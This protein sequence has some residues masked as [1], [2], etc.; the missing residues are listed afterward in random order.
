MLII[1]KKG[2][3][4]IK[5]INPRLE[6]IKKQK[7]EIKKEMKECYNLERLFELDEAYDILDKDEREILN[8]IGVKT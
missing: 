2:G 6:E 8:N 3:I 7:S 1:P 5:K 4:T